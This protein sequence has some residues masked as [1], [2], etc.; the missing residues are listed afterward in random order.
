MLVDGSNYE[1][2][3]TDLKKLQQN[4]FLQFVGLLGVLDD[5]KKVYQNLSVR[6]GLKLDDS[7]MAS[8]SHKAT[9]IFTI[10]V[11][12]LSIYDSYNLQVVTN[13]SV[14]YQIE[15]LT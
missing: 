1:S 15:G 8:S 4:V 3:H 12:D 13:A 14:I 2:T 6:S 11:K 5:S 9:V 7:K 10:L